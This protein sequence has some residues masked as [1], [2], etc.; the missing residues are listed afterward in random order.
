[1]TKQQ[2]QRVRKRNVAWWRHFTGARPAMWVSLATTVSLFAGDKV[3]GEWRW[4]HDTVV[5]VETTV[6]ADKANSDAVHQALWE[7]A[8]RVTD[9]CDQACR[10]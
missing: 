8:R 3:Y 4:I 9:R 10:K 5:R 6:A 2:R 7:K 1:M